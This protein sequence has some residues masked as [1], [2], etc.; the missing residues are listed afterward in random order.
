ML[1]EGC[2]CEAVLPL[3]LTASLTLP[4]LATT[5]PRFPLTRAPTPQH[6]C[7]RAQALQRECD[8]LRRQLARC[9]PSEVDRLHSELVAAKRAAAEGG[10]AAAAADR[11][12]GMWQ[13]AEERL[14]KLQVGRGGGTLC[15]M[16][17]KLSL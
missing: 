10:A 7:E 9:D 17:C 1:A 8:E 6:S 13:G 15:C 14:A 4:N 3:S 11:A 2:S 5:H 12:R 16:P